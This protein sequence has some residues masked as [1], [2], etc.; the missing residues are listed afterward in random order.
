[1]PH[2]YHNAG[3]S[4]VELLLV[5]GSRNSSN[6]NRL[7]EVARANGVASYLID[8]AGEIDPAWVEGVTTVGHAVD[9]V[10]AKV[11]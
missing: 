7:V 5:I 10:L 9:M 4:A 2:R 3:R 11:G 6:S 8:D 1:M